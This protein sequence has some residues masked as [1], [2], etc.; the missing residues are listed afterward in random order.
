MGTINQRERI[1]EAARRRFAH[2]GFSKTTLT[3]I[4]EELSLTKQALGYYFPDKK[5]LLHAVTTEVLEEYL[6][7]LRQRLDAAP[8]VAAALEAL[9]DVQAR[10]YRQYHLFLG[11]LEREGQLYTRSVK[12]ILL[13][14]ARREEQ[15][16]AACLRSGIGRGELRPL[17]PLPAVRL[18][19]E[20]LSG[21]ADRACRKGLPDEHDLDTLVVRQRGLVRLIC[22]GLYK[23]EWKN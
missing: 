10:Y 5:A 11:Q 21:L 1:M 2:F 22:A 17:Q 13:Q 16:L 6:R 12:A 4:A 19:V 23:Q 18:L 14:V 15:L 7:D 3:E 20:A 8:T 9:V